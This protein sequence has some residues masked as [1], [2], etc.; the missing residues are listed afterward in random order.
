MTTYTGVNMNTGEVDLDIDS[1]NNN[2][3]NEDGDWFLAY[4]IEQT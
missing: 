3:G 4:W 1:D 2:D